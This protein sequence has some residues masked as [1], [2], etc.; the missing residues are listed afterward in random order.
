MQ[1][2][3]QPGVDVERHGAV[4][5]R[6]NGPLV[7]GHGVALQALEVVEGKRTVDGQRT[8]CR[9]SFGNQ[10]SKPLTM[11]G[12]HLPGLRRRRRPQQGESRRQI[13]RASWSLMMSMF[14]PVGNEPQPFDKGR[15]AVLDLDLGRACSERFG[16]EIDK[17]Q[18]G[19]WS[20]GQ[21]DVDEL[22]GARV[23][24]AASLDLE[25]DCTLLSASISGPHRP[26]FGRA[27]RSGR[28]PYAGR[29]S[30]P[31]HRPRS[32]LRR[33]SAAAE[34]GSGASLPGEPRKGSA[35]H[36]RSCSDGSR[37]VAAC[38]PDF[39]GRAGG[40]HNS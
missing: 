37:P 18:A 32:R 34:C 22:V 28:T 39:D 33:G 40:N 25:A 36:R 6:G 29:G 26:D 5:Q 4:R 23:E 38:H 3:R 1:A 21:A 11:C 16:V 20:E 27:G 24:S 9:W 31:G 17:D 30:R 10:R 7:Q 8:L 19:L 14:R 12:L 13:D 35:G 2:L 15:E